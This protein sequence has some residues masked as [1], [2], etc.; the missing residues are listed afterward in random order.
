MTHKI[1]SKICHCCKKTLHKLLIFVIQR[2]ALYFSDTS[3]NSLPMWTFVAIFFCL[4][5]AI[6]IAILSWHVF[7]LERQ[8]HD[9]ADIIAAGKEAD[10]ILQE[11]QQQFDNARNQANQGLQNARQQADEILQ[12]TQQKYE[13]IRTDA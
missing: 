9:H 5:F 4:I 12:T 13:N 8:L 6:A 11:A 10:K 7:R 3:L 2:I 1:R